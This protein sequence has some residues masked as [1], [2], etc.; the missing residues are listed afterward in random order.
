[1]TTC[2]KKSVTREVFFA[3]RGQQRHITSSTNVNGRCGGDNNAFA[4]RA[5]NI[6]TSCI[7][8]S[9]LFANASLCACCRAPWVGG[10]VLRPRATE[11]FQWARAWRQSELRRAKCSWP[12]WLWP[13]RPASKRHRT[14]RV[15]L[16]HMKTSNSPLKDLFLRNGH[17]RVPPSNSFDCRSHAPGVRFQQ[18]QPCTSRERSGDNISR[19]ARALK[20]MS[21]T[22]RVDVRIVSG[23]NPRPWL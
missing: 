7:R 13:L 18:Q 2:T 5:S 23:A 3:Q 14:S 16:S 4:L 19:H 1:M 11:R 21:S 12:L 17:E 20:I 15:D 10:R 6:A 22:H 8:N 9:K